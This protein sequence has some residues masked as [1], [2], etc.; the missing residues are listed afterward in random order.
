MTYKLIWQVFE[1]FNMFL[2]VLWH[3]ECNK[4]NLILKFNEFLIKGPI[5]DFEVVL[6]PLFSS[7]YRGTKSLHILIS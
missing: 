6:G 1:G 7:I 4:T 2:H 3:G 5:L